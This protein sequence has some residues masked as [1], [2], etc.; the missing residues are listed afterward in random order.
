METAYLPVEIIFLWYLF[1]SRVQGDSPKFSKENFFQH[2][3][4]LHVAP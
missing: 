3:S 1:Y 4:S 2:F